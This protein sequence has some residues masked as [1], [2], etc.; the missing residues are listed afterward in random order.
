[1]I[2]WRIT[3]TGGWAGRR[4]AEFLLEKNVTDLC[5]DEWQ[6]VRQVVIAWRTT[7]GGESAS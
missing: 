3:G 2:L 4:L 6:E 7:K 1:M 5:A